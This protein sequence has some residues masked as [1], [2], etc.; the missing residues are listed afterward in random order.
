MVLFFFLIVKKDDNDVWVLAFY[1]FWLIWFPLSSIFGYLSRGVRID[2]GRP[3]LIL[4]IFA[5]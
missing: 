5:K 4:L 1:G 3:K 2:F